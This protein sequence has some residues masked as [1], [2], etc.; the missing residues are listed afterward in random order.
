LWNEFFTTYISPEAITN[1]SANSCY[2]LPG[3]QLCDQ[4]GKM[5]NLEDLGISNSKVSLPHLAE[6]LKTCKEITQLDFSYQHL[7]PGVENQNNQFG[8]QPVKDA[9]KKLTSLKIST[10]VLNA[11]DYENDPWIFIIRMLRL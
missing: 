8:T 11:R 7:I 1:F 10:A 3:N 5:I 9:F 6:I 2:W 4:I